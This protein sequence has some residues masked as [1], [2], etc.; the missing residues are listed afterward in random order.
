MSVIE[1]GRV[2]LNKALENCD[3]YLKYPKSTLKNFHFCDEVPFTF[4]VLDL[5]SKEGMSLLE[6]KK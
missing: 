5:E 1:I 4:F 6:L 3:F 2:K